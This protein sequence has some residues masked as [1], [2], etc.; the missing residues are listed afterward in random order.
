MNFI[1]YNS[2]MS[3]KILQNVRLIQKCIVVRDDGKILALKRSLDDHSRGGNWDLPGGGYEQGEDVISAITREVQEEAGLI[4]HNPQPIFF[5]NKIGVKEG[6]FEGDTVFGICYLCLDWDGEV[7]LS[8]EHV[9]SQ[10]VKPN[11]FLGY[12]F[13]ADSGFFKASLE[14]YIKQSISNTTD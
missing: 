5:A 13:G 6:F 1:S 7:V 14:G 11:D 2:L 4:V 10:W 8:S 3:N 12:D 9:E